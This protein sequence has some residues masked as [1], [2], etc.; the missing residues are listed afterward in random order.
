M[1]FLNKVYVQSKVIVI[2]MKD[3]KSKKYEKH[4]YFFECRMIFLIG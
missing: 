2:Q 3:F 1:G 4:L